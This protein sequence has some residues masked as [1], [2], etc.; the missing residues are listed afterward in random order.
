MDEIEAWAARDKNGR[1]YLYLRK[2]E[3][4]V[5]QWALPDLGVDFIRL[6]RES[7]TEVQ[8]TDEEPTKVKIKI[9]K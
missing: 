9:E 8:W 4:N 3:K 6:G 1:L 2:P 7:F 5:E